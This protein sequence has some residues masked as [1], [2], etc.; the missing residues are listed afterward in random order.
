MTAATASSSNPGTLRAAGALT[1]ATLSYLIFGATF[2]ALVAFVAGVLPG[3]PASGD[4]W[5]A[6][7]ADVGLVL[8]FGLQHSIM[9]RQG[10]KRVWARLVPQPI[11][12]ATYVLAA[13]LTLGSVIVFWQP[14]P[15]TVW[16]IESV[17]GS[18]LIWTVF[19]LAWAQVLY[20]TFLIDHFELFGLR[21][22]WAYAFGRP[23]PEPSFKTPTVYRLVRHPMQLGF[24]IAF[25]ATPV[26][27]VDRLAIAA[28]LTTYIVTAL[29]F[30][31]RDLVAAFGDEYRRYQRR[32]PKLLPRLW[33][34]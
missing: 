2:L 34:R 24:M 20:T 29:V 17:A 15:G 18:V 32:V 26:M 9:A 6:A 11:E 12:R 1:Y 30:E 21:Q 5:R 31:E 10:F 25:W 7:L 28:L 13:S 14:L 16:R 8:A 22:A 19:A 4:P 27:T 23:M 3:K 33:P